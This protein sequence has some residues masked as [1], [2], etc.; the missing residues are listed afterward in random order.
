[1][2]GELVHLLKNILRSLRPHQW[3]KNLFVFAGILF[4]RNILETDLF[5]T[6]L[7]AFVVF[8][9]LSG[10]VYLLNDIVDV[11]RDRSHP[12]KSRRPIASGALPV[13]A[14]IMMLVLLALVAL[15]AAYAMGT[16]FFITAIAYLVLQLAYSFYLK[17]QVI[18]DVFSLAAGFVLRVV[19]GAVVI[20][21]KVSSWLLLCTILL[22]LFLGFSKRRHEIET[23]EDDAKQH[24]RV[25][26]E[27]STYLL[28]QMIGVV[29]A[30]TVVCYALYTMSAETID[31]FG[32]KNLIFTIPFVLYGIF[33]YLYL[34]H[35][36][37]EGGNPET[38]LVTDKP[39]LFSIFLWI[40]TAGIIIYI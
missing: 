17:H 16:G 31:K 4:S 24:R 22:S 27:Y 8:C 23:L 5:L 12:V 10:V 36:K 29:T 11:E 21:V 15:C 28:D 7:A 40:L 35:K 26:D 14:A 37:G 34:I 18:L 6:V 3:I 30:S 25:L 33:R 32:T 39:L 38:V 13:P 1:V 9:L 2:K 20:D 19:A